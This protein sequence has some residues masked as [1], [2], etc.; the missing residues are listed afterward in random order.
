M[1]NSYGRPYMPVSGG[2]V[3]PTSVIS[4]SSLPGKV[5][6]LNNLAYRASERDVIAEFERR[7]HR[8]DRASIPREHNR[9]RGGGK[10][11][12]YALLYFPNSTSAYRAYEELQHMGGLQFHQRSTYMTWH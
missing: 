7:G 2:R 1:T 11:L 8:L 12:G 3:V 10:P 4:T 6:K 5:I 9:G